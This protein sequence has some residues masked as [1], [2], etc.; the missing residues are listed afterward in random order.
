M[1]ARQ[2]MLDRVRRAAA[3]RPVEAAVPRDYRGA[4]QDP[5]DAEHL[6]DV[7]VDR[8]RDYKAGVVRCSDAD[9]A[10]A[11][12][13]LLRGHAARDVVVPAGFPEHWLPGD[14]ELVRDVPALTAQQLDAV[15]AV[16]TTSAVAI[17]E[18]GTI[19][20]DAGP[21]MGRRAVTLVPDLHVVVVRQADIVRG[22]PE[23]LRRIDPW[24]PLTW[25]S[26]PSATSDIELDR[27]EGVHGPRRLEVLIV[28][29]R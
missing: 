2:E 13:D 21:G 14:V 5:W 6:V 16:L 18:T 8:L 12:T 29:A 27:V 26:G 22:V 3:V 28:Q 15:S 23:A 17:A 25:I 1:S 10:G 9:A 19:V 4:D 11:L 7:L 20:L 24:Q